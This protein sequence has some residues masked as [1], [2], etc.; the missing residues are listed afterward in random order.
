MSEL[1][2]LFVT[3]RV[4]YMP[5]NYFELF[6]TFL[7]LRADWVKGL[8]LLDN[9]DQ[10]TFI[11][12]L[13]L[14]LLGAK[15]IGFQ[16]L[17]NIFE[18]PFKKREKL[19]TKHSIPTVAWPSMNCKEALNFVKENEI[20]LIVNLRTRCIYKSPILSAPKIGCLNIHHGLLPDYR[21]TL[22]DLYAL[23]EDR[24][25]GFS[26]HEMVE[27]I[28]AGILHAVVPVASKEETLENK[29]FS[30]MKYLKMTGKK[31]AQSLYDL[32]TKIES[33][34]SFPEGL[35]NTPSKKSFTKNPNKKQ[36]KEFIQKGFIL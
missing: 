32:C 31:E 4:T 8:V 13:G 30:Y 9:L 27:K 29:K 2:I 10:K 35:D 22:C 7:K 16:L 11:Q 36:I 28:D 12:T 23:T 33:S 18:L 6:E 21:G 25:A 15:Q 3:S 5:D 20:D 34:G 19:F 17:K 1:R 24:S 14:P 26:I